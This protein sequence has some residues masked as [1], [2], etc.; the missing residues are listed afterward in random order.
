MKAVDVIRANPEFYKII[1]DPFSG[2]EVVVA[3]PIKA[4]I[5]VIHVAKCDVRGN[6]IEYGMPDPLHKAAHKVI[7]TTDEIVPQ[8]YIEA[9]HYEVSVLGQ[10]VD[11]VVK[12]P[13]GAHPG[14]SAGNYT[15]DGH[16]RAYPASREGRRELQRIPGSL[17][18]WKNTRTIPERNWGR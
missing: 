3:R 17:R 9:H 8:S 15:H 6:G 10:F 16:L 5:C 2:R 11:V 7:V 13:Y 1:N 12:A 18:H 4:D 14:E